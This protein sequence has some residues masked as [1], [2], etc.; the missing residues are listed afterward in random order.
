[1]SHVKRGEEAIREE[2]RRKRKRSEGRR[3]EQK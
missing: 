1:V 2:S 3:K